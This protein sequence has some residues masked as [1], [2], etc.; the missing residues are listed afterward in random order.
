MV[1]AF[2]VLRD[3]KLHDLTRCIKH[4]VMPSHCKRTAGGLC[5]GA[6]DVEPGVFRS[7]YCN[8][9]TFL[10][11]N[12]TRSTAWRKKEL[13][14]MALLHSGGMGIITSHQSMAIGSFPH[15][16]HAAFFMRELEKLLEN[17]ESPTQRNEQTENR[18]TNA[19]VLETTRRHS[20]KELHHG[21]SCL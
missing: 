13:L 16:T 5:C 19:I 21:N 1:K 8:V 3:G 15:F 10:G 20:K 9:T 7:Q 14:D 6:I 17:P 18:D 12:N 4:D 2:K 11:Q